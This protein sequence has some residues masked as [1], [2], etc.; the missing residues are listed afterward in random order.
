LYQSL[1]SKRKGVTFYCTS[2]SA[3]VIQPPPQDLNLYCVT[4]GTAAAGVVEG[5]LAAEANHL[6]FI[7]EC[8]PVPLLDWEYCERFCNISSNFRPEDTHDAPDGAAGPLYL[9][10]LFHM[11]LF[12]YCTC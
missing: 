10:N 6:N 7:I 3:V 5:M 11:T 4:F 1:C 8:D 9:A 2:Q 12:I